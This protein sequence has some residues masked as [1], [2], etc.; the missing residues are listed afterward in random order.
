MFLPKT[1]APNN[2]YEMIKFITSLFIKFINDENAQV[3]V[4]YMLVMAILI[5]ACY[6][7]IQLITSAWNERFNKIVNLR[8]GILG[9][10]P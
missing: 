7:A 6:G 3:T 5:L 9:I 10:G 1:N 2:K 4:E 8:S